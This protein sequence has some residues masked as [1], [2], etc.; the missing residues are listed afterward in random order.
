MPV[1]RL[2]GVPRAGP[3][4]SWT[5]WLGDP[6]DMARRTERWPAGSGA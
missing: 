1:T 5:M 3:P 4:T 6:D 2:L